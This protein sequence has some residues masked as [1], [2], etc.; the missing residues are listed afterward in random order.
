VLF[1]G[2]CE[3]LSDKTNLSLNLSKKEEKVEKAEKQV[4]ALK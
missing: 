3:L 4:T 1:E 2:A